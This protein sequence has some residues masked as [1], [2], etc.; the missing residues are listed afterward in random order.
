MAP[1]YG[2][3]CL[4]VLVPIVPAYILFKTLGSTAQATGKEFFGFSVQLGGAFAG[5][6]VLILLLAH[7]FHDYFV[8]PQSQIVYHLIGRVQDD[9][10][11]GLALT[12]DNFLLTPEPSPPVATTAGG[13]F[14]VSFLVDPKSSVGYPVVEV[15]YGDYVPTDLHLDPNSP[16][17]PYDK[18]LI[19][20]R[21]DIHHVIYA[22]PINLTKAD[23]TRDIH[24]TQLKEVGASVTEVKPRAAQAAPA[25]YR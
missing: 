21:D 2:L 23:T 8:L 4:L 17:S 19:V 3:L 15:S 7:V 9:Q 6:F 22:N 11:R 16:Q 5:Y 14:D 25:G 10:K 13:Y 24:V 20:K 1:V 12:K 18:Q